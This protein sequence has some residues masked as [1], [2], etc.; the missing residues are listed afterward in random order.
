MA[1]APAPKFKRRSRSKAKARGLKR[2]VRGRAAAPAAP[3]PT[4]RRRAPAG[5]RAASAAKRARPACDGEVLALQ[6]SPGLSAAAR[7]LLAGAGPRPEARQPAAP[8]VA[9]PR[10]ELRCYEVL[11]LSR[12]ATPE[13]IR[14]AYRR[15]ALMA[16]PDKAPGGHAAFL[17]LAEAFETLSD[18]SAREVY[19]REIVIS[20]SQDGLAQP[21]SSSTCVAGP[22]ENTA[23]ICR[24]LVA[25]PVADWSRRI[26]AISTDVLEGLRAH[27]EDPAGHMASASANKS[28]ESEVAENELRRATKGMQC[29]LTSGPYLCAQVC[30]GGIT[31]RSRWTKCIGIAADCHIALVTLKETLMLNRKETP[32]MPFESSFRR[33]LMQAQAQNIVLSWEEFNYFFHK[34]LTLKPGET[35]QLRTPTVRTVEAALAHRREMLDLLEKGASRTRIQRRISQLKRAER[36]AQVVWREQRWKVEQQLLGY[37]TRELEQRRFL[38]AC[39]PSRRRLQG[40]QSATHMCLRLPWFGRFASA[41]GL[42][43]SELSMHLQSL[44]VRLQGSLNL[45]RSVQSALQ[46]RIQPSALR[47]LPVPLAGGG[48]AAAAATGPAGPAGAGHE[49]PPGRREEPGREARGHR[50]TLTAEPPAR[51]G[52]RSEVAGQPEA[53]ATP[54]LPEQGEHREQPMQA[55]SRGAAAADAS[56]GRSAALPRGSE[57]RHSLG[58][59]QLVWMDTWTHCHRA[60]EQGMLMTSASVAMVSEFNGQPSQMPQER[61]VA[62]AS[63]PVIMEVESD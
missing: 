31:I 23:M 37:I 60:Y 27:L 56:T 9:R 52:A 7:G 48:P 42:S 59:G 20:D 17:S 1:A 21:G 41:Q 43:R 22:Q 24:A 14:R 47:D 38:G 18:R 63:G 34:M 40:K 33:A 3:A 5:A 54:P 12:A 45:Q 58:P 13:E 4:R 15:R 25:T 36:I 44:Q 16:H 61:S 50:V 51:R 10:R 53:P 39:V 2:R 6:N 19:D 32:A 26:M 49:E 46:D 30:I 8:V 35:W 11:G 55:V 62:R 28:P 29:L 57:G